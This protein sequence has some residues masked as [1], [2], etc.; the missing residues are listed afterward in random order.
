MLPTLSSVHKIFFPCTVAA[1]LTYRKTSD[2]SPRLLTVQIVLA[3]GLYL[4]CG[5]YAGPGFYQIILKSLCTLI[6]FWDFGTI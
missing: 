2:R 6:L 5:V 3:A 4:G 1:N